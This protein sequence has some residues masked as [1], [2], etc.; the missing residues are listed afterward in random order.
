LTLVQPNTKKLKVRK[1]IFV[2]EIK[3]K[4]LMENLIFSESFKGLNIKNKN[5]TV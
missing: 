3:G 2:P 5:R 1:A 4:V